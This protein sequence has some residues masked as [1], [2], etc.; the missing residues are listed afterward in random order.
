MKEKPMAKSEISRLVK[1]ALVV[2]GGIAGMAA[3]I[4]L[5]ERDV[6]VDLVDIDPDWRVYGT[7]ITLSIL[8]MRALCDLGFARELLEKG[9]GQDGL[10]MFDAKGNLITRLSSPRL[11]SEDVPG[12]GGIL[13]PVLHK[14]MSQKVRALGA[15]I[16]LGVKV[17]SLCDDGGGVDV[18]FSDA[19]RA[20]YDIVL[21]ADGL[22]S[23][24][25]DRLFP[26]APKPQFTGQ[27]CWRVLFDIP[28]GWD[29]NRMYIGQKVKLGFTLCAP[30]KMY[31]YLLE[32]VPT[33]PRVHEAD[34]VPKLRD[35]MAEFGGTV[36]RLREEIT[37]RHDINYR[38]LEAIILEETW[39]RG[40]TVLLG[41]AAHATTP[42]LGSGAGMAVE[43]A[44]ALVQELDK[45][46]SINAAFGRY[47][48]RRL[49]RGKFVVGNSLK[50]GELEM[51]GAPMAEMASLMGQ[52]FQEIAKPY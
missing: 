46:D 41:D 30:D 32:T 15:D 26:E 52:C 8:T 42:H 38:P 11:Y 24:M 21:G 2:G 50:L 22:F 5:R 17:E 37:P 45:G 23:N 20:R 39:F 1:K 19:A 47:L 10:T 31:M 29:S 48:L 18:A 51:A 33:N 12:E 44:I 3:A 27:A 36:A 16:R 28:E 43:D 9:S 7:G 40:R 13:R 35:M 49:P 25:R 4:R 6:A 14:L 34:Y